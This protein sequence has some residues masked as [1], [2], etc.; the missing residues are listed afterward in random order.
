ME[1]ASQ[2]GADAGRRRPPRFAPTKFAVPAR[3]GAVLARPGLVDRL[4][5]VAPGA[6]RLVVGSPGSGKS[7][8]LVEWARHRGVAPVAW[9][10]LDRADGDPVRFWQA[11]I[12]AVAAVAPGFG[13]EAFDLLTLDGRVEQDALESLLID[14]DALASPVVLVIDDFHHTGRDVADQ[15]AHL[16][17]RGLRRIEVALGSRRDPG[18][19]LGRLRLDGRLVEVREADLRL[20]EA[21][22]AELVGLL[23]GSL[24][25][26]ATDV[27]VLHRRTEGWAA[28]IRLAVAT[29][30]VEGAG[31]LDRFAG[32]NQALAP[33][34]SAELLDAQPAEIRRFLLDTCIVDELSP[35]LAAELT[36]GSPVTLADLEARHVLLVRTDDAGTTYRYHHLFAELLRHRLGVEAPD[37]QI[38][39]HERAATW[40]ER[41]G[42][43]V[44]AFRHA[45]RAG[46][47]RAAI[48]LVDGSVLAEYFAGRPHSVA[49]AAA[50]LTDADLRAAGSAAASVAVALAVEG[51]IAEAAAL[52]ERV[53]RVAGRE[54]DPAGRLRLLTAREVVALV[55]G[56][57]EGA[58]ALAGRVD[59][60]VD[61]APHLADEDA[62]WIAL[63]RLTRVR[64]R[65]WVDDLVGLDRQ[66]TQP[67]R[68]VSP[69]THADHLAA[70][71]FAR[72]AT[73][74]FADAHD[75]AQAALAVLDGWPEHAE[76]LGALPEAVLGTVLLEQDHRDAAEPIL[77]RALALTTPLR[78]P[79]ALLALLGLSRIRHADGSF[80]AA[81]A[82]LDEADALLRSAPAG[83]AMGAVT[84]ARRARVLAATG[85]RTE[86]E[87]VV[88]GLGAGATSTVVA[89]H[90]G[91]DPHAWERVEPADP[92]G[93]T[94]LAALD[95]ELA[96]L[97]GALAAGDE[98]ADEI[99]SSALDL[100]V[101]TGALLPVAEAG[102]EVLDALRQEARRRP[103]RAL[104]ER[105]ARIRPHAVVGDRAEV[106][107]VEPLSERERTV[108]RYLDTAMS[109]REIAEDLYVSLNTVKTHVKNVIRKLEVSSRDE[110]VARARALGYL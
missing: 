72:L 23:D 97:R 70:M 89:A 38:V 92:A 93:P 32:T 110:A 78:R 91:F 52:G 34:L 37:R 82:L 60:L 88:D 69:L 16:L 48:D 64:A 65:V 81:L 56:D 90:L 44:A 103:R 100:V 63:A 9:L 25:L 55:L 71:A 42:D 30:E 54:L 77:R 99:A 11:A 49:E 46:R 21:E 7:T 107:L 8:L 3:P 43:P 83:G 15:L 40:F 95:R 10:G 58:L 68:V 6:L 31:F 57:A 35:A 36:G 101:A 17:E 18:G 19:G 73:G 33:Y 106:R 41:E 62:E 50:S 86:A 27:A 39:L 26:A 94:S 14:A 66:H 13:E 105:L 53:E 29:M 45:W 84:S 51:A 67:P 87:A 104:L 75:A 47:R 59:G 5:R 98:G 61:A 109:Y 28:G 96:R 24:G 102:A 12:A 74:R 2:G 4:D 1:G 79:A 22:V 80:D 85:R 108:L 20:D 76:D